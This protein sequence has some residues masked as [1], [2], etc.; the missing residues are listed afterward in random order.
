MFRL[1]QW[2]DLLLL[3]DHLPRNSAFAEAMSE[4]EEVAEEYLNATRGDKPKSARPRISEWSAEVERM[5]DM[6]DR[7]GEMIQAIVA[8][9]GGKAPK[10][11]PQP[12]PKTAIDRV[13]ER[14]RYE[15]HRKVVSRVLIQQ[16]DG[17]TVP[18]SIGPPRPK[19]TVP[20]KLAPIDPTKPVMIPGEDPF[21]LKAPRR[22]PPAP[23][24]GA[25]TGEPIQPA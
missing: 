1:R 20:A 13:R 7:M 17:T 9:N 10:L 2:R 18:L 8:S 21:R 14:K 3:V 19:K 12:R 16:E 23:E 25:V 11:R 6:I 24:G 15:Q 4:D 5:T 22:R